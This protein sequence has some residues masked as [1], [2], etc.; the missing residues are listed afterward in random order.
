[1][2]QKVSEIEGE[3]VVGRHYL[4]PCIID[5]PLGSWRP[6]IGTPHDDIE[7]FGFKRVHYHYDW[8]FLDDT[9]CLVIANCFDMDPAR[10]GDLM[11]A[12]APTESPVKLK[13][14]KCLRRMPTFGLPFP[15]IKA[16]NRWA[17][18]ERHYAEQHLALC[19]RCPH[20][21]APLANLPKDEGG[22]VVCPMH[23]LKWNLET[24]K[25]VSRL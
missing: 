3:P 7:H 20:R 15:S 23:G 5:G 22:N 1:M 9:E 21:G 19:L 10:L 18:F 12:V 11:A 6:I 2:I 17:K 16:E 8:R 4:V 25:L 13:R 14:L 24:G